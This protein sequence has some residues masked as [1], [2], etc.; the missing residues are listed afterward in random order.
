MSPITERDALILK[1]LS[2]YHILRAGQ[3]RQLVF[4]ESDL[5]VCRKRLKRLVN[6]AFIRF[7]DPPKSSPIQERIYFCAPL[8]QSFVRQNFP[9]LKTPI[10]KKVNPKQYASLTHQ[11]EINEFRINL[12]KAAAKHP[13]VELENLMSKNEIWG[14]SQK[15]Q[16]M[17]R[18]K[19]YQEFYRKGFGPPLRFFPDLRFTLQGTGNMEHQKRLYFL[20][21][22]QNKDLEVIR[23]KIIA[24]GLWHKQ[25]QDFLATM[26]NTYKVLIQ[27]RGIKRANRIAKALFH[28]EGTEQVWIT[29]EDCIN[30]NLLTQPIWTNHERQLKAILKG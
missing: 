15:R 21:V 28:M 1:S 4:A 18:Y 22:D 29:H 12:D 14:N 9:H 8:G 23:D 11:L 10:F 20:E 5:Q 27:C 19:L 6:A 30:E 16:G 13:W 7:I 25:N 3:V 17:K 2:Q 24:Y 26:G